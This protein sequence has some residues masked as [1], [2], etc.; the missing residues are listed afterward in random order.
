MS[1]IHNGWMIDGGTDWLVHA[2]GKDIE[3][4]IYC[5]Q[6]LNKAEHQTPVPSQLIPLSGPQRD[7]ELGED[8]TLLCILWRV[9]G[10]VIFLFSYTLFLPLPQRSI[11]LLGHLRQSGGVDWCPFRLLDLSFPFSSTQVLR[12]LSRSPSHLFSSPSVINPLP[13]FYLQSLSLITH[14]SA[15]FSLCLSFH[16]GS[17]YPTTVWSFMSSCLAM[18]KDHWATLTHATKILGSIPHHLQMVLLQINAGLN[19]KVKQHWSNK[20]LNIAKQSQMQ[21]FFVLSMSH[22]CNLF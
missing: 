17:L 7:G 10:A 3:A 19:C 1:Y 14:S 11:F 20:H 16:P 6:R 5:Q 13:P 9:S 2:F 4:F 15:F 18:L 22:V 21:T 12:I 8:M